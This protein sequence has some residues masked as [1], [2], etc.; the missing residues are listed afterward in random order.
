MTDSDTL[1]FS[2]RDLLKGGG[3]GKKGLNRATAPADT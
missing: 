2:R 1:C 3:G